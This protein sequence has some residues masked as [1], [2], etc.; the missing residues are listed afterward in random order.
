MNESSR[1]VY[2]HCSYVFLTLAMT[3]VD[4]WCDLNCRGKKT[5]DT[6]T[7]S[8]SWLLYVPFPVP[9]IAKGNDKVFP[10]SSIVAVEFFHFLKEF[11]FS[12]T[13]RSTHIQQLDIKFCVSIIFTLM[14]TQIFH[15]QSVSGWKSLV[16]FC[17]LPPTLFLFWWKSI[18]FPLYNEKKNERESEP[19]R[20][21]LPAS[22]S[23]TRVNER[24]NVALE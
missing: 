1:R 17:F 11:P 16:V 3:Y 15:H 13:A 2:Y 10:L 21:L 7:A 4:I 18:N 19:K 20:L 14:E 5:K 23:E 12:W 6:K 22:N 8:S 9:F 24:K